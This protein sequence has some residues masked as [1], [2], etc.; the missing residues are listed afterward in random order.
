VSIVYPLVKAIVKA[1]QEYGPVK[2]SDVMPVKEVTQE[3][4]SYSLAAG[5]SVDKDIGSITDRTAIIV[6]VKASFNASAT[7]GVRLYWLYSP[8]GTNFDDET[9]AE[10][11]GNY[12]DI[13]Y[14]KDKNFVGAGK[15]MQKTVIIPYVTPYIRLRLKN[16]DSSYAVTVDM[17]RTLLK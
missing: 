5:G 14:D 16:L 6:T 7:A 9:S 13:G 12:A 10:A 4:S 15:T 8:D 17:W 3:L 1:L 2:S 11:E